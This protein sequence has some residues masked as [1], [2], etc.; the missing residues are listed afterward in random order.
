MGVWRAAPTRCARQLPS[1]R[2]DQLLDVSLVVVA[3]HR[4]PKQR[5]AVVIEARHL[6]PV[7][8]EEPPLQLLRIACRRQLDR[9][10]LAELGRRR[11]Q[12][13]LLHE[14]LDAARGT[15]RRTS[16]Q[17]HSRWNSIAAGTERNAAGSRVPCQLVPFR[18]LRFRPAPA[19]DER[20]EPRLSSGRAQRKPAP[21]GAHSHLWP[22]PA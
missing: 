19:D 22:L 3:L 18:E 13:A 8:V 4:D 2:L 20:V 14:P 9:D 21:F 6:D 16:S 17:P 1:H 10:H 15:A 5:A 12:A 7:L 11:R